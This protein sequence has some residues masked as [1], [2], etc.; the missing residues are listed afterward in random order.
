MPVGF[1][2]ACQRRSMAAKQKKCFRTFFRQGVCKAH[3][4][5]KMTHTHLD[6]SVH[7]DYNPLYEAHQINPGIAE[8]GRFIGQPKG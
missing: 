5:H 4:S 3:A 8:V 1:D 2:H 6:G 7:T